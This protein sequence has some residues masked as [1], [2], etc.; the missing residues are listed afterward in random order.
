MHITVLFLHVLYTL[1]LHLSSALLYLSGFLRFFLSFCVNFILCLFVSHYRG[2]HTEAA[3]RRLR[4]VTGSHILPPVGCAFPPSL[5]HLLHPSTSVVPAVVPCRSVFSSSSGLLCRGTYRILLPSRV[6]VTLCVSQLF[7][8]P[9]STYQPALSTSANEPLISTI[10]S[11][12]TTHLTHILSDTRAAA[13]HLPHTDLPPAP[14][15]LPSPFHLP[16]SARRSPHT[17]LSPPQL[18]T[19]LSPHTHLS[20]IHI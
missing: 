18:P 7:L 4:I 15:L 3:G 1:Y 20:L 12:H 10:T 5:L 13:T 6:C 2:G 8:L 14:L 16:I 11:H 9:L 19:K 17:Q